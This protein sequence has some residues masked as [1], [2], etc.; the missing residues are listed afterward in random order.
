M[1]YNVIFATYG[2]TDVNMWKSENKIK[3]TIWKKVK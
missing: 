2:L 1:F 3:L